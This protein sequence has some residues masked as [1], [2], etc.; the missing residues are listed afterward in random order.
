MGPT[1]CYVTLT[2]SHTWLFPELDTIPNWNNQALAQEF[3][4]WMKANFQ[5]GIC[6]GQISIYLEKSP[7]SW[8]V[9][10]LPLVFRQLFGPYELPLGPSYRLSLLIRLMKGGFCCL[11]PKEHS[12]VQ[13]AQ[14]Q[15][16]LYERALSLHKNVNP[17][18]KA[19]SLWREVR[20]IKSS[21]NDGWSLD[22]VNDKYRR[23]KFKGEKKALKLLNREGH[24]QHSLTEDYLAVPWRMDC[25][26]CL[27]PWEG[28]DNSHRNAVPRSLL[29]LCL[30]FSPPAP[31]LEPRTESPWAKFYWSER[32]KREHWQNLMTKCWDPRREGAKR[33]WQSQPSLAIS[34]KPEMAGSMMMLGYIYEDKYSIDRLFQGVA[35]TPR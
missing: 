33:S 15:V 9:P 5:P 29:L 4:T 16:Y 3:E 1:L 12:R 17:W 35:E 30:W 25:K 10:A 32:L 19:Q 13:W 28:C 6:W 2:S 34:T 26:I 23:M 21:W 31:S 8:S 20:G 27:A 7:Q 22:T 14:Q 11:Q 18:A 24:G